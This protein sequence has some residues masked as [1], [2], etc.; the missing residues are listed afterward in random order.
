MRFDYTKLSTK[1]FDLPTNWKVVK[2]KDLARINEL[3]ITQKVNMKMIEYIDIDSVENGRILNVQHLAL[4]SAPT[5]ARRIVRNN[6]ILI[7][8][9]RPNLKHFAFIKNA[10]QNT[11]AS[12]GFA[13]ITAYK[14][15]PRFLYYYLT[16]KPFTTYLTQIAETSTSAYPSFTPDVIENAELLLPP[17]LE[18]NE[19]AEILGSLDDKIELNCEMNKTL[20]AIAQ[21]IFKNWFVDFEPFKDELVYNEEVSREIPKG[22]EVKTFSEVIYINPPR[23]L[24][25]GT[26]ARKIS[27][28]DLK[29]WQS[30]VESWSYEK[31]YGGPTFQNGDT[32]FARITPSLEHGK[33]ALIL[34]LDE[35]EIAF[36]TTEFI[37]LAPKI[38]NS[39]YFVFC[40]ART[41]EVRER[42]IRSMSG[43]SGR[44]RVPD[45]IFDHILIPIP[46]D[47]IVKKFDNI[48]NPLFEIITI[49]SNE[50]R[51]LTQIRDALLPKLLSG[52]I[53]IKVD[54]EK[55]FPEQVKKLEEIGKEKVKLQGS[56]DMWLK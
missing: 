26:V 24:K 43:S 48:A 15:N 46:P 21:A 37:V 20:E 23:K 16:S 55:E 11:I 51:V 40:L 28:P 1:K 2:V 17:P 22:W 12:T 42:A 35:G 33:T 13:V 41:H 34:I 27:M 53:R 19:I 3:S 4:T 9:V 30:W 6:D 52:E 8:T 56:L 38:I 54:V 49:N 45:D 32:L 7:S 36:G 47:E 44:Q 29:P 25:R 50:N 10:K 5:R 39:K 18:Q 31:Y 14:V